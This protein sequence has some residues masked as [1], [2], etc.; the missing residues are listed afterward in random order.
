MLCAHVQPCFERALGER[1][2]GE[3]KDEGARSCRMYMSNHVSS[4]RSESAPTARAEVIPLFCPSF[5][6]IINA[7]SFSVDGALMALRFSAR[8]VS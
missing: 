3:D 5:A 2:Y 8:C 6:Y 4:G 7:P 1:P